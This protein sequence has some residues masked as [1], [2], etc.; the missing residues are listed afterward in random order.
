[1]RTIQ[2]R[3]V[4]LV[5]VLIA[6]MA[7]GLVAAAPAAALPIGTPKTGMVCLNGKAGSGTRQFDLVADSGTVQTPDGNTVFMWSYAADGAAGYPAFQSPGPVLCATQGEA[8]TIHLRNALPAATSIIFPG[9]DT[10]VTA[11]GGAPGPLTTE[12]AASGGTVTYQFTASQP[13]TY[14]YESGSDPALQIE[15]GLYGALIIRPTG[16]ADQAYGS[17]ATRFDPN[18][19][20]L[21]LLAE[22]DPEVHHAVE[23]GAVVLYTGRLAGPLKYTDAALPPEHTTVVPGVQL[24]A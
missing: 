6:A 20:Y 7:G 13:G 21:M 22:I 23:T 9:Q 24:I 15:M 14:L 4:R 5:A 19:E 3:R 8:V 17:V 18:R 10:P 1:M 11:S 12:A 16:A 2:L